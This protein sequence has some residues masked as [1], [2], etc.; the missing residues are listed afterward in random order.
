MPEVNSTE[1]E[2][3][4][5]EQKKKLIKITQKTKDLA[6]EL[7]LEV[8]PNSLFKKGK[9]WLSIK[10]SSFLN[11]DTQ[12]LAEIMILG[13]FMGTINIIKSLADCKDA[14]SEI[15]TLSRELKKIEEDGVNELVP[16]LERAKK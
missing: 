14:R 16:F 12:H 7:E 8:K 11:D 10:T 13:Y 15:L 9:M 1:L 6:K 4:I 2:N 5:R 3:T